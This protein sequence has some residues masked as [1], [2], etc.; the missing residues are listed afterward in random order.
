MSWSG[1]ILVV[2]GVLLL[3][4]NFNL[5][6]YGWLHQWWPVPIIALGVMTI[7]RP[8]RGRRSSAPERDDTVRADDKR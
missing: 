8:R 1:I 3:A 2:V 5:L 7:L 6:P 4:N